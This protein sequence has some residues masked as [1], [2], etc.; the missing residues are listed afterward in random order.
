VVEE[1]LEALRLAFSDADAVDDELLFEAEFSVSDAVSAALEVLAAV[2]AL[3]L[4]VLV[5]DPPL[6]AV[7]VS[8]EVPPVDEV[9]P[10]PEALLVC[11]ELPDDAALLE[12]GKMREGIGVVAVAPVSLVEAV[13]LLV[14]ALFA[15][16][17]AVS[18]AD[19]TSLELLAL[20]ADAARVAA[21]DLLELVVKLSVLV[22]LLLCEWLKEALS[23]FEE[24]LVS[25]SFCE[26][27]ASSWLFAPRL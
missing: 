19:F 25:V 10:P 5:E 4:V 9:A 3:P 23:V 26:W 14:L 15:D 22:S 7:R 24:L 13:L 8:V 20:F 1:L 6:A 18:L 21:N 2:F 16:R 12:T 27:V 17:F 11:D